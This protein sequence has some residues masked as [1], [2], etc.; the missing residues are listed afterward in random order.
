MMSERIADFIHNVRDLMH[1]RRFT[2]VRG[3]QDE[4]VAEHS[5]YTTLYAM[6]I[7]DLEASE[8]RG[9]NVSEVLRRCLLHDLD[10]A[11]V[12][13]IPSPIKHANP[14]VQSTI[15]K[16]SAQVY[17]ELISPLP[18][19][20]RSEYSRLWTKDSSYEAKIQKAA[21]LLEA[22]TWTIEEQTMGNMRVKSL[23]IAE[24]LFGEIKKVGVPTA[25]TIAENLMS[26]IR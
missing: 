8:G 14:D 18:L 23:E 6:L 9:A 15:T 16:I 4:S 25:I 5:Y 24:H 12:S 11:R 1:V 3:F 13:D 26:E 17:E 7:C 2:T 10:E 20:V 19:N 21:D 22:L